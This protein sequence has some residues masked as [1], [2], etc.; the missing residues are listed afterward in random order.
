MFGKGLGRLSRERRGRGKRG[1]EEL[2]GRA[3][4]GTCATLERP[5]DF[6]GRGGVGGLYWQLR[7][8][9][10][11]G[12]SSFVISVILLLRSRGPGGPPC[13]SQEAEGAPPG[14]TGAREERAELRGLLHGGVSL[15][16]RVPG[17]ERAGA[18]RGGWWPGGL[19]GAEGLVEI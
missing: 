19:L 10:R 11:R 17:P 4:R 2:R 3:P 7:P 9:R 13:A 12:V 6:R 14:A 5:G 15:A 18:R 8:D 1:G 16:V